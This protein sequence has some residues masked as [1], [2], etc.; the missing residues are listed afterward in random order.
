MTRFFTH[1]EADYA[2]DVCPSCGVLH[3]FPRILYD[4]ARRKKVNG[5][6][7]CPN[8]HSWHYTG[9]T[10]LEIVR[11]ERDHLKQQMAYK[12]DMINRVLADRDKA[13]KELKATTK[14]LKAVKT[15]TGN[16]VCPCCHRT[17]SQLQRHM[18][19]KHPEFKAEEVT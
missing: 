3:A 4:A 6:I 5:S 15:R 17:F 16:G 10:E 1:S 12:D 2:L 14:Q 8:G 19:T 11:R 18:N 7:T 9:D 13:T